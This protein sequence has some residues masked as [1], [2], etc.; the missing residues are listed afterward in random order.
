LAKRERKLGPFYRGGK[1][2]SLGGGEALAG[3]GG[4]IIKRVAAG[5]RENKKRKSLGVM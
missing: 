2:L 1:I 3:E 5:K 4:K